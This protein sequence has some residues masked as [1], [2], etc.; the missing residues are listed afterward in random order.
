MNVIA[1]VSNEEG[2]RGHIYPRAVGS[3][4]ITASSDG[5]TSPPVTFRVDAAIIQSIALT[6]STPQALPVD[7]TL[8]ITAEATLSDGNKVDVTIPAVFASDNERAAV[9][10]NNQPNNGTVTG[11]GAGLANITASRDGVTSPPTEV[12]V[13]VATPDQKTIEE[14]LGGCCEGTAIQLEGTVGSF[15]GD[16]RYDLNDGTGSIVLQWS[17]DRMTVG[18]NV[19]VA[20]VPQGDIVVVSNWTEAT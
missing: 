2:M 6:P 14:V 13:T 5:L 1:F 11:V 4:T 16:R 19:R 12:V 7:G 10:T 17:G 20:G 8:K 3:V 15:D 9:V 18:S